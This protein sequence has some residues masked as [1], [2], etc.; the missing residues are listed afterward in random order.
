MSFGSSSG[1]ARNRKEKYLRFFENHEKNEKRTAR[2]FPFHL[3]VTC[4]RFAQTNA[5]EGVK[6]TRCGTFI[7]AEI[8]EEIEK[9]YQRIDMK[10]RFD[11]AADGG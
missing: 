10:N 4:P 1:R 11:D 9:V 8:L 7:E 3:T 2:R 5:Y 6:E